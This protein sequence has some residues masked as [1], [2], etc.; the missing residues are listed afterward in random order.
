M[1]AIA[2]MIVDW[3][4]NCGGGRPSALAIWAIGPN[5]WPYR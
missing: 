1:F 3:V 2:G 4:R 5:D